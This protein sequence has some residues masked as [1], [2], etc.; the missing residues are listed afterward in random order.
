MSRYPIKRS[1]VW[2]WALLVI[3]ATESSSYVDIGPDEIVAQFGWKR[4]VV[5]R[6]DVDYAERS[7]WPWWGGIGW[8]S[9]L[10]H[11]I[12]LI[13]A[14][15][16]I[17]RIHTKPRRTSLLGIPVTLTDLYLSVE[18]PEAAVRELSSSST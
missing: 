9:D 5:P 4:I 6:T 7:A 16:P 18:D 8:R 13:G 10:R 15:S 11:S 17:L 2:A 3:G 12:G 14:L 1:P